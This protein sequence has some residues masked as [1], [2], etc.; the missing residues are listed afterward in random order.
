MSLLHLNARQLT[1]VG[2][3][4][5]LVGWIAAIRSFC[6]H[7]GV[8]YGLSSMYAILIGL[9]EYRGRRGKLC[10]WLGLTGLIFFLCSLWWPLSSVSG[11]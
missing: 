6:G 9:G 8:Y 2:L 10:F 1:S 4:L 3:V 5:A 11:R 7:P